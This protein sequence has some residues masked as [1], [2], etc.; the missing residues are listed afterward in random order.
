MEARRA[1]K[2]SEAFSR[3]S[4]FGVENTARGVQVHYLDHHAYFVR[5]SCFWPF[6]FNLGRVSHEEGQVA[7]IEAQLTA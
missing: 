7:E 5:E 2:I 1:R 3:I 6:A 4:A